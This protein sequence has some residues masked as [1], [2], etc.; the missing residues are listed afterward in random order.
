MLTN[1]KPE[2][3]NQE[4]FHEVCLKEICLTWKPKNPQE[5]V[6]LQAWEF[7]IIDF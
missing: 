5:I 3:L 7:H 1:E 2:A 4:E 6:I